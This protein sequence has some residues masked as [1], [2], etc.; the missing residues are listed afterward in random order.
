MDKGNITTVITASV[1]VMEADTESTTK[2]ASAVAITGRGANAA[3][4]K[5][6]MGT[7]AVVMKATSR[8][9]LGDGL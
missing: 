3:V 1:A 6:D 8:F 7:S 5:A 9:T 2:G 4:T